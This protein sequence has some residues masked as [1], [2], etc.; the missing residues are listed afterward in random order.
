MRP[1]WRRQHA[2]KA[3]SR[4]KP[5]GRTTPALGV[6]LLV[7]RC[8]WSRE[9]RIR[10][11]LARGQPLC[12]TADRGCPCLRARSFRVAAHAWVKPSHAQPMHSPLDMSALQASERHSSGRCGVP[13]DGGYWSRE[14]LSCVDDATDKPC[15]TSLFCYGP[16]R[17]RAAKG[18]N[19]SAHP[20]L[21]IHARSATPP[22]HAKLFCNRAA[23]FPCAQVFVAA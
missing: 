6:R 21:P 11:P 8:Q 7:G 18:R 2:K 13:P 9:E 16:T 3:P 4:P 12:L 1:S 10:Q 14:L 20:R 22:T 15:C 19:C 23:D 5:A 17:K